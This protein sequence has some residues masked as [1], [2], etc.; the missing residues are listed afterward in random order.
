ML[1]IK[2]TTKKIAIQI[3]RNISVPSFFLKVMQNPYIGITLFSIQKKWR[4][5][6]E[7]FRMARIMDNMYMS[8]F[9]GI[10]WI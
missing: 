5:N 10:Y 8:K 7:K 2:N 1:Q 6:K 3:K 4:L 9:T